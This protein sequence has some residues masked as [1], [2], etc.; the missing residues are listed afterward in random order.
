M[1]HVVTMLECSNAAF[2][3]LLEKKAL[4]NYILSSGK[5]TKP[6]E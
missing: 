4:K 1:L 6:L 5:R 3:M 2:L